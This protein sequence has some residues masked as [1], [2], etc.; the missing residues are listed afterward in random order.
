MA[1]ERNIA[2]EMRTKS[3]VEELPGRA[4]HL[5]FFQR[6][7]T[8]TIAGRPVWPERFRPTPALERMPSEVRRNAAKPPR[9]LIVDDDSGQRSL[10]DSFLSSQGFDTVPVASGEQALETLR[11]GQFSMMISDVRMPGISGLETLRRVRKEYSMLP[12]LLVT[13]Y[14]DIREAVGAMRDGAVNYLAKPIDLDE[15][16]HTVQQAT[17]IAKAAPVKF[18]AEQQLPAGVIASSPLMLAVFHD[19]SL[20]APSESR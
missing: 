2:P 6:R 14:A 4:A 1:H 5:T 11:G 13:A 8:V 7:R 16:L 20:I 10:L 15:L 12:V 19:A 3:R 9:I 17:G 18:S